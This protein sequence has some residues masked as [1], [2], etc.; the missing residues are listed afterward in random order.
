MY[1]WMQWNEKLLRYYVILLLY[2]TW[3]STEHDKH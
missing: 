2:F 3:V 1:V